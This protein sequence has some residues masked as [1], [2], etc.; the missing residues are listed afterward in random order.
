MILIAAIQDPVRKMIPGTP[1]Y[2]TLS[3]MPVWFSMIFKAMP[4]LSGYRNEFKLN[5]PQ[6]TSI[7]KI[8]ILS[9]IP[10]ALISASYGPGSWQITIIGLIFYSSLFFGVLFGYMFTARGDEILQRVLI[11]YCLLTAFMLIGT[12]LEY[13]GRFHYLKVLGTSAFDALWIRH[14][15]H[16]MVKLISGFYRSPDIMGWHSVTMT[17]LSLLLA[18]QS[19]GKERYFW[20]GLAGWGVVGVMLCGRRKMMYMLPIYG[21]VLSWLLW[22]VQSNRF[23]FKKMFVVILLGIFAGYG[24]YGIVGSSTDV[25]NYYFKGTGD[26]PFERFK[27]QG[28]N[29]LMVTYQQSGFWGE[30]LGTA[31]QGIHHLNVARPR[32]WQEG[33]LSKVLVELG[34]PGFLGFVLVF[35]ILIKSIW[36]MIAVKLDKNSPYFVFWG[37]LFAVLCGNAVAFVVSGQIFGDPFITIFISFISGVILSPARTVGQT[38]EK[39]YKAAPSQG[40]SM[41]RTIRS[42]V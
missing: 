23:Q 7:V 13:W 36:T 24:I 3:I 4:F 10:A 39:E 20:I 29:A 25:E 19:K 37:G 15:E 5:F 42:R 11:F 9:I 27:Q 12:P 28:L 32:T 35:A 33:G 31:T 8:F 41:K 14:M 26:D 18:L 30:G 21:F 2:L 22:R 16:G 17:M 40:G 34:V 6:L 1:G 38:A